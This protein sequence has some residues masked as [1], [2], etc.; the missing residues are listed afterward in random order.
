MYTY[1]Y[2]YV[3]L[4][5]P[6]RASLPHPELRGHDRR[7]IVFV[8]LLYTLLFPLHCTISVYGSTSRLRITVPLS[9]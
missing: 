3:S 8:L 4:L 6:Y 9:F 7:S 2:T 5:C 1:V